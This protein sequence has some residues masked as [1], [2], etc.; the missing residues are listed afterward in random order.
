MKRRR[1]MNLYIYVQFLAKNKD[2]I[3]PDKYI[4]IYKKYSEYFSNF[5]ILKDIMRSLGWLILKGLLYLVGIMS[6]LIDSAFDFLNFMQSDSFTIMYNTLRPFIWTVF[7]FAL[8]YLAYC[9][10]FAHEKPKGTITNL[11]IFAGTIVLLP[12]MMVQMTNMLTY[13]KDTLTSSVNTG[14]YELLD[15]Y[16]ADMVYL[17]SINFKYAEINKGNINGYKSGN[18]EA[19]E[20]MDINE[21]VDP[22]D[23]KK[24][25]NKNLF[26]KQLVSVIDK[27]TNTVKVD[28]IKK[29]KFFFKDTTPYYY[30]YHVNFFVAML[31]LLAL[32]IVMAFSS[33]KLIHLV[34]ELAAEKVLVPFIAA[35]DLTN[36]QKIRKAL[37]GILN[38]YITIICVL[39]LQKLFVVSTEYINSVKWSDN[40]VA[41]G[42]TKA[43]FIVAGA[44]FIVD[45]PN[46]FEQIFGIDAGLKSVGQA[47]QSAYYSSQMMQALKSG[48]TGKASKIGSAAKGIPNGMKSGAQAAVNMTAGAVGMAE[49]MKDTGLLQ[50]QNEK[51]S[52]QMA[53]SGEQID[54]RA[55]V[56]EGIQ[57][58]MQ[59]SAAKDNSVPGPDDL[60]G[61]GKANLAA[62]DNKMGQKKM[63]EGILGNG[64]KENLQNHNREIGNMLQSQNSSNPLDSSEETAFTGNQINMPNTNNIAPSTEPGDNLMDWAKNNTKSGRTIAGNYNKGKSLGRAIGNTLNTVPKNLSNTKLDENRNKDNLK[65]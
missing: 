41:N 48:V 18:Y 65:G 17:D 34:Y 62:V 45:G 10:M 60:S 50:S 6:S 51:V 21:I 8:M 31:Y 26:K 32:I 20:Y 24:L 39:F 36:G 12:Y 42:L 9:Y 7:F 5:S 23:Y 27:G 54:N 33:V 61:A 59:Q 47:L 29:S 46:F 38:G 22:D 56:N 52:D 63:S 14:S 37:T 28:D 25:K 44:L 53:K 16:I 40:V 4:D 55:S 2:K 15:P 49:G 11:L 57:N 19:I 64:G 58:Q 13:V 1:S 30:R 35:G 3:D 43:V